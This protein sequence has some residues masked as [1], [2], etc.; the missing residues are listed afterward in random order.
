MPSSSWFVYL[1]RTRHNTLY[2]GI[3][4]DVSQRLREHQ[5]GKQGAKYLRSKGPLAVVY[6]A[7]IGSR[8]L[9]SKVEYRIKKLTKSRK[10]N[11]VSDPPDAQKLLALL[12]ISSDTALS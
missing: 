2:T 4:T 11:I 8:S 1:I 3:T 6:Q 5:Q 12:K 7:E 9:A 10:E